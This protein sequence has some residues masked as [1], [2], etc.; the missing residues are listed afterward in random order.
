MTSQNRGTVGPAGCKFSH[1]SEKHERVLF[2]T[3]KGEEYFNEDKGAASGWDSMWQRFME[4][5]L[6]E[7]NVKERFTEHDRARSARA[8]SCRWN[9][10][11]RCSRMP[12]VSSRNACIAGGRSV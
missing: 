5:I 3:R 8:T 7:T 4:R 6:T 12:I 1:A 10:P 2:C 9:M 11:A